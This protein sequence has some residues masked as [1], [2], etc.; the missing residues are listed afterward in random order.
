[1]TNSFRQKYAIVLGASSGIGRGI[2][3]RLLADGWFVALAARRASLLKELCEEYPQQTLAM[4]IDVDAA[5]APECLEALIRKLKTVDLYVHASGIGKQNQQLDRMVEQ[6][7]VTTNALGFTNM[8]D[9]VFQHMAVNGG[10]QIAAVTS[11]AGTKGLGAAPSYS[12][13]KAFQNVYL[14]ALQQLSNMRKLKIHLTDIRP[15]FVDTPLLAE[16]KYPMKME[17]GYATDLM[18]RAI[19]RRKHVVVVDWKYC[20]LTFFWRWLP[21]CLWRRLRIATK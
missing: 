4:V 12:A 20:V 15:G 9:T 5:D 8:I 18:V 19:Y 10:G 13:T 7:T 1:M 3:R 16:G 17:A 6:A 21:H 11:I 14:E 2:A